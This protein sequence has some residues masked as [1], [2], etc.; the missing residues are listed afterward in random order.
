MGSGLKKSE[1]FGTELLTLFERF[2]TFGATGA[3]GINRLAASEADREARDFLCQWLQEQGFQV[4][5]D[6]V[7]NIF[8]IFDLETGQANSYFFCGS[9]LDSQPGGGRFDGTYGVASACI[10][11]LAIRNAVRKGDLDP[12]CR[13]FVVVCWTGEE[14]ARFQPSLLGSGVFTGA[15]PVED[16]LSAIDAQGT[17][18][19]DALSAIGYHGTGQG[20][21][22]DHNI[23]IHIEQGP[24]LEAAGKD[25]G[26]V[27]SCWGARKLR[28]QI[29]GRPDHTGPTP[30]ADRKD[31][32]L[33]AAHVIT[34]VHELATGAWAP[35]HGSVGRIQIEPNSPNTVAAQAMLWI[36]LRSGDETALGR[37]EADLRA[38]FEDVA[39][40]TGCKLQVLSSERREAI[41]FDRAARSVVEAALD[42]AGLGHMAMPTIAGHDAINL[43]RI[44]PSTLIFVPS[45]NGISHSPDE[46]TSE[47]AM[48]QGLKALT[49][50]VSKLISS[51]GETTN[52][53]DA[54]A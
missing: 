53:V 23:E 4:I 22:P 29:A 51:R 32:L 2:C 10:T 3:G 36:E 49:E 21:R 17:T 24:K 50:A 38:I 19:R 15:I 6:A 34:R 33:A 42:E 26:V 28:L 25:V 54:H 5:V 7:G 40:L 27:T 48:I 41:E 37:V 45:Q 8:G 43:Q 20:P 13:F 39:S 9:H 1:D 30:M 12:R 47:Q 52:A 16:A 18:L 46:F 14:G 35:V 44:C 31:A 11:S